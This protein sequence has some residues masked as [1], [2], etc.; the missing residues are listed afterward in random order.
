MV[1]KMNPAEEVHTGS[2]CAQGYFVRMEF[3][4]QPF[5]EKKR[6]RGQELFESDTVMREYDKIVGITH[7]PLGLQP[8]LHELIKLVEVYIREKL[9]RKIAERKTLPG[10][11]A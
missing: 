1:R 2:T 8:M 11:S 7:I 3:E 4:A 5:A 6:H 10:H 9:R